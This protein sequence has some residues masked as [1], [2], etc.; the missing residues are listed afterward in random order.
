MTH[1]RPVRKVNIANHVVLYNVHT[2]GT[3]M[4]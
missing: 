3:L 1:V 4:S 2:E